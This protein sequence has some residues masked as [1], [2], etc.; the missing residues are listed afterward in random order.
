MSTVL[1]AACEA[2][3]IAAS[4]TPDSR[5]DG[6]RF[7]QARIEDAVQCAALIYASGEREFDYFLG[8]PPD[9]CI[10]FLEAAFRSSTGR[11][12]WR[13]HHLAV[14]SGGIVLGMLAVHDGRAILWDDPHIALALARFFGLRRAI[15]MLLRG[16]VL[17]SEL[18][19]PTRNQ[20]LMAHCATVAM[21]RSRGVFSALFRHAIE[22]GAFDAAAG[23]QLVLDVLVSNGAAKALYE[24]LGFAAATRRRE[25]SG[26]LPAMLRSTRMMLAANPRLFVDR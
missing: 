4:S 11:F 20:T 22:S 17:E 10:A 19:K 3:E 14:D 12:S 5:I 7:R 9:A 15:G 26:R 2:T 8:V 6:M 13:R 25:R 23:R 1:D 16:L 24:R 21:A 18:P